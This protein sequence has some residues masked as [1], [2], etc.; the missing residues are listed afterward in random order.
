MVQ[1][2]CAWESIKSPAAGLL[3]DGAPAGEKLASASNRRK[4]FG[5]RE[6]LPYFDRQE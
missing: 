3:S 1:Y 6:K 4:L 5:A 2:P